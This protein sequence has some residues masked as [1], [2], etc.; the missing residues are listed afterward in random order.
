MSRR[1][2]TIITVAAVV[3]AVV[4]VT[5]RIHVTHS[6]NIS[7]GANAGAGAEPP[8]PKGWTPQGGPVRSAVVHTD[9]HGGQVVTAHLPNGTPVSAISCPDGIT[10]LTGTEATNG[11][12]TSASV[13]A[14]GGGPTT[15]NCHVP[16][17]GT[18]K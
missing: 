1:A 8:T 3:V 17:V 13:G 9:A 16:G 12:S 7:A 15:K 6:V 11:T 18:T 4:A 14:T 2:Q 5:T 10:Y